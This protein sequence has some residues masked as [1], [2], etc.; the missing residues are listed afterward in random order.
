MKCRYCQTEFGTANPLSLGD[1]H[2]REQAKA[3][4]KGLLST[5]VALFAISLS[6]VCAAPL[7]AIINC[8]MLLPKRKQIA[9]ASPVHL[10]LAY[11]AI[12]ITV[13]YSILMLLFVIFQGK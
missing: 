5:V 8:A 3:N 12:G 13:L 2:R 4:P 6:S 11:S 9:A 7:M 1:M 10:V